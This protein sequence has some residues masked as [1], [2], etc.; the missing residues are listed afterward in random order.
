MTSLRDLSARY[1]SAFKLKR[2]GLV[3]ATLVG[4]S[5]VSGVAL[6]ERLGPSLG[7]ASWVLAQKKTDAA[8]LTDEQKKQNATKMVGDMKNDLSEI[9]Q[10]LK[11][12]NKDLIV[13]DCIEKNYNSARPL[14]DAG[15]S[16]EGDLDSALAVN[17]SAKTLVAYQKIVLNSRKV[18]KLL[19][20]AKGCGKA[21]TEKAADGEQEVTVEEPIELLATKDPTNFRSPTLSG[22][23]DAGDKNRNPIDGGLLGAFY[24]SGGTGPV[25]DVDFSPQ[26]GKR[27]GTQDDFGDDIPTDEDLE[28]EPIRVP[29]PQRPEGCCV[30]N[31]RT[32]SG[33]SNQ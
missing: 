23:N 9:L 8:S 12:N 16:A 4:A 29:N 22:D 26:G 3:F 17:N 32:G 31:F 13:R 19:E 27:V 24:Q 20:K 11:D 2:S 21:D 6:A 7:A 10:L 33:G 5:L 14:V 30:S 28:F 18:K 15:N 25:T 1:S